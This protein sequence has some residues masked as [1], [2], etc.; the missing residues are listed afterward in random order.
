MRT[1]NCG[2]TKKNR[3]LCSWAMCVHYSMYNCEQ[4]VLCHTELMEPQRGFCNVAFLCACSLAEKHIVIHKSDETAIA[5]GFCWG[6][7]RDVIAP[8]FEYMYATYIVYVCGVL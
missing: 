1:E 3:A 7:C 8:L 6:E 2:K 5:G 4:L